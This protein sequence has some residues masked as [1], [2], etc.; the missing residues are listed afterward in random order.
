[1]TKPNIDPSAD[2]L[3]GKLYE[4]KL[5]RYFLKKHYEVLCLSMRRKFDAEYEE[6]TLKISQ[7]QAELG[8]Y[9]NN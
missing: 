9:T 4:L 2:E 8:K 3:I 5:E 1:M 7:V 6:L